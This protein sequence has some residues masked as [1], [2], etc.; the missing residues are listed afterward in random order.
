MSPVSICKFDEFQV[1][2]D[3]S[4]R[5]SEIDEKPQEPLEAAVS[6]NKLCKVD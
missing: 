6:L 3:K 5:A 1:S 4:Q 2:I